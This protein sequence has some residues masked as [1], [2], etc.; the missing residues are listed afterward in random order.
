MW[1]RQEGAPSRERGKAQRLSQSRTDVPRGRLLQVVLVVLGEGRRAELLEVHV[2]LAAVV[3]PTRDLPSTGRTP[4]G[5]G[6]SGLVERLQR[7]GAGGS[8]TNWKS[9]S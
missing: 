4:G 1:G 5:P 9:S 2:V 7:S 6:C 8:S 3:D